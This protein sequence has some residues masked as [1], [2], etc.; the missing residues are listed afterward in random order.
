MLDIWLWGHEGWAHDSSKKHRNSGQVLSA[1]SSRKSHETLR[2]DSMSRSVQG[3]PTEK[4]GMG[5]GCNN[6]ILL[7]HTLKLML[8]LVTLGG[9]QRA[10]RPTRD[11]EHRLAH[12]LR[13]GLNAHIKIRETFTEC[14]FTVSGQ[15]VK[16][17]RGFPP[18]HTG[19]LETD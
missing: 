16:R 14:A 13:I 8:N 18:G 9:G 10:I 15:N 11:H 3:S 1:I 4:K 6:F 19:S 2:E 17:K 12:L 7:Q 5:E